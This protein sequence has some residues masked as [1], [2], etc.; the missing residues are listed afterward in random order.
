[1]NSKK[2]KNIPG[3]MHLRQKRYLNNIVEQEHRFIKKP[4]PSTQGFKCV[5]TATSILS[6][7]LQYKI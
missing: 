4:R 6:L 7:D 5:N 3:G 2:E 1:M